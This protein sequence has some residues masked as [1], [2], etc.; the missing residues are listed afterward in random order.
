MP[1][2][3]ELAGISQE[4]ASY[5]H[6]L[7]SMYLIRDPMDPA[8]RSIFPFLLGTTVLACFHW[9]MII[10]HSFCGIYVCEDT[11]DWH[12]FKYRATPGQ[13]RI[14]LLQEVAMLCVIP[15]I[16]G[17]LLG[18][19]IS[20]WIMG[21]PMYWQVIQQDGRKLSGSITLGF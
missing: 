5:H 14:C 15:V 16:A 18:I 17:N 13:I 12:F 19:L 6:S 2:I 21:R 4:A 20:V 8:P 9:I 3:A 10:N 7:L 1:K 11:S